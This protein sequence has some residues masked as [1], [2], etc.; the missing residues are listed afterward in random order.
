MARFPGLCLWFMAMAL[1]LAGC[2]NTG[3]GSLGDTLNL[4]RE[5]VYFYE[6]NAWERNAS[7]LQPKMSIT[8]M[9]LLEETGERLVF[10]VRDPFTGSV[11]AKSSAT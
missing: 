8:D 4:R 1:M 3:P 9:R 7:C 10:D 11:Y 5:I 6:R 2:A